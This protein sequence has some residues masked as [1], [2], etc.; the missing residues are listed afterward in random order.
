MPSPESR[1]PLVHRPRRLR[2]RPRLRDLVR[3][4]SLDV[5]D[6][7][8]PLFV[9]HGENVRR[10]I[11]SMPGQYQLSLDQL[12][13]AARE[14]AA[15]GVPAV[16]LF[17]IPEHKDAVGS[18]AWAAD[19]VVQRAI[20]ILKRAAPDLLVITD[21][22]FCEYTNHGHC[23][24]LLERG[25][26]FEV[27]NDQTLELLARQAVSHAQAG[28]D[29]IAPSGMMDGMVGAIRHGLDAHGFDQI[30]I[31]SY[32]VKFASGYYGPFREAAGS[33]PGFGDRRGYQMDFRRGARE[34]VR[35]ARLD[36]SEGADIIMVKPAMPYLDIL[37]SV[38][39]AVD[40][41]CAAY[42]VSG[43]YAMFKAAASAGWI[44]EKQCVLETMH[45]IR[46]AGA[47]FI[48]TYYASEIV[49]WLG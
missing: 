15:L 35:E 16:I 33:S 38:A 6:L 24:P 30:P 11:G 39:D 49:D 26:G 40:V 17:G 4:T 46:R 12:D 48:I 42:Q 37:Q 19:G 45:A 41:P 25:G 10:E 20:E 8:Y 27:D 5:Q 1:G 2:G 34:A 18:A 28:A 7:V 29:V 21:L 32:A 36:V 31:L 22:C 23:G 9:H 47:S 44:D 14:T 13:R 3:E 43:E